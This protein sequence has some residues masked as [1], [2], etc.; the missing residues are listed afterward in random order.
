MPNYTLDWSNAG[1][2]GTFATGSGNV[3]IASTTTAAGR[4]ANVGVNGNPA[5]E[6]LWVSGL[7]EPVSTTITFDSPVTNLSFELF[8]V[9]SKGSTWDDKVTVIATDA[10]GNQV[11]IT[12]S[13]LDG[14]HSVADGNVINADGNA[15]GGVETTGADDSVTVAIAG[16]ITSL[17]II[18]DNGES[19]QNTGIIGLSDI[20][21]DLPPDYI[22]EGTSG[23]DVIDASY[24]GD[25]EGDMVDNNDAA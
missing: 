3:S 2:N 7:R 22:V 17:T 21:Y 12:V 13:D 10:N 24:A 16:P 23:D 6:A 19:A 25:P 18:F 1:A 20:S 14:L 5:T 8:D 11:P 4:T 15:S 9:D